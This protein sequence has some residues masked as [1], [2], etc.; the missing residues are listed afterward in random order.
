M[1][2]VDINMALK[3]Y[4][5]CMNGMAELANENFID[6]QYSGQTY[7]CSYETHMQMIDKL[8]Q[9]QCNPIQ[10]QDDCDANETD[11]LC[12]SYQNIDINTNLTKKHYPNQ[13]SIP[14]GIEAHMGPQVR[15]GGVTNDILKPNKHLWS[16]DHHPIKFNF[17]GQNWAPITVESIDKC[18]K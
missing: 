9:E 12:Y 2:H 16:L 3:L 18:L 10:S 4:N 14:H 15:P 11:N 5:G 13:S 17:I 8:S 1:S 7:G 6:D